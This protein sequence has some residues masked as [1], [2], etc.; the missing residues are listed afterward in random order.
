MK[1]DLL[2][3]QNGAEID[4]TP[5]K[6]REIMGALPKDG[7]DIISDNFE[8]QNPTEQNAQD[9]SMPAGI[10]FTWSL[11]GNLQFVTD[12]ILEIS[13]KRDF[14][15]SEKYF[16]FAGQMFLTLTNFLT[17]TEYFWRMTAFRDEETVS[18]S[19]VFSFKTLNTTPRWF[20]VKG[21]C[22]IR[23]IG[24][25]D[26]DCGKKVKFGMLYRGTELNHTVKIEKSRLDFL[27]NDLKIKTDIDLRRDREI[28]GVYSSPIPG[29]GWL[30]FPVLPYHLISSSKDNYRRLFKTLA[31][32]S[33]YP[34]YMH[35]LAGADRTGTAV[36]LLLALLGVEQENLFREYEYTSLS[37]AG[38]RSRRN[39]IFCGFL[40]YL[41]SYGSTP[42][43]QSERFLLSCG[44]TP[45]EINK[46]RDIFLK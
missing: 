15:A 5:K 13:S 21:A 39:M 42:K 18:Q 22:N 17:D 10:I 43:K 19:E 37:S 28:S 30:S 12:I 35:C 40:D 24:G 11:S 20:Y 26:T 23:D 27:K 9:F 32:D 31:D 29:V 38:M 41:K 4:I 36:F 44:I 7:D 46:I 14:S 1:I 33:I 16:I 45:D 25:Y 2:S 3:P 6:Q 34:A 8:W